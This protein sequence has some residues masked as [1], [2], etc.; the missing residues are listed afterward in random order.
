MEENYDRLSKKIIESL[1]EGDKLDTP[2]LNY[3]HKTYTPNQIILEIENKTEFGLY[4]V[5]NL[6]LLAFDLLNRHKETI[7]NIEK[8]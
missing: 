3:G 7:E 8:I 2:Y 1:K 4:F 5:D 6:V